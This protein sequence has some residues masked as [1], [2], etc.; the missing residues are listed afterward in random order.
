MRFDGK[1]TSWN[2]ATGS[3]VI[4]PAKGGDDIAAQASAFPHEQARP[5]SSLITGALVIL[6]ASAALYYASMRHD[7]GQAPA[8]VPPET[9]QAAELAHE[10]RSDP[11]AASRFAR[12]GSASAKPNARPGP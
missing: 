4:T 3:G 9:G 6:A 5:A 2:H 8:A 10:H 11:V 12:P 1:L 7:G